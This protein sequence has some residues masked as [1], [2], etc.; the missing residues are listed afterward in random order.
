MLILYSEYPKEEKLEGETWLASKSMF[1]LYS[2]LYS[3]CFHVP[4]IFI[5]SC[6]YVLASGLS[7]H[8]AASPD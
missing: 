5:Q 8:S 1:V 2:T 7:D 3:A 6:F 4:I